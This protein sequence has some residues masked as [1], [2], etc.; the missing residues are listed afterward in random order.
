MAGYIKENGST[1]KQIVPRIRVE[2]SGV[3]S[4]WKKPD[5]AWIKTASGWKQW[6]ANNVPAPTLSVTSSTTTSV[7]ISITNYNAI[8]TYSTPTATFGTASRS[9]GTIT[10]T[11]LTAG[12]ATTV[13]IISNLLGTDSDPGQILTS[14][15]PA[16]PTFA[17]STNVTFTSFTVPISN[18]NATY[19]YTV[20]TNAGTVTRNGADINVAGL[21]GPNSSATITVTATT[22][23][24]RSAAPTQVIRSSQALIVPTISTSNPTLQGFSISVGNVSAGYTYTVTAYKTSNPNEGIALTKINDTSYTASGGAPNTSYTAAV[25]GTISGYNTTTS[26]SSTTTLALTN[27]GNP[28]VTTT[29]S[30]LTATIPTASYNSGY[31]Y[32][33]SISPSAGTLSI[34][35]RD[36][37]W[38]G[39]AP[40]TTYTVSVFGTINLSGTNYNT[41]TGSASGTTSSLNSFTLTTTSSSTTSMNII[42]NNYDAAYTYAYPAASTLKSGATLSNPVINTTAKTLT[43]TYSG[44]DKDAQYSV[45]VTQSINSGGNTY[46]SSQTINAITMPIALGGT[47]FTVGSYK[48][49]VFSSPGTFILNEPKGL[50]WVV[51]GGGGGGSGYSTSTYTGTSPAISKLNGAGGGGGGGKV[52]WNS[53]PTNVATGSYSVFVGSGGTGGGSGIGGSGG[54]SSFGSFVQSDGG[55]AGGGAGGA[56]GNLGPG[57]FP[58]GGGGGAGQRRWESTPGPSIQLAAPGATP[59]GSSGFANNT[60]FAQHA[61]GGGGGVSNAGASSANTGGAGGG[62][63]GLGAFTQGGGLIYYGAGGGGAGFV[64]GGVGGAPG[65]GG[66]TGQA[67][68]TAATA[69]SSPGGGGGGGHNYNSTQTTGGRAGAAGTVRIR[70]IP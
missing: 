64:T 66:G 52:W 29:L 13:S 61:G 32:T 59:G 2:N 65:G 67:G 60:T 21:S 48:V 5:S 20:T 23:Q 26:T 3:D 47:S 56:S 68:A 70:Y 58:G 41:T 36:A 57:F 7:T 22:P 6:Y 44:L 53:A 17:Q 50:E 24:G 10:V 54:S 31:T 14:S 16:T 1:W 28:T 30:S 8:Y 38:T 51:V 62:G 15:T 34:S 43:R 55:G 25:F 11:G 33:W 42:V 9:A 63:L 49:H 35:G 4:D 40:A 12:Q 37:T 69:G 39:L 46:S 45:T 19:S 18:Y 27:P